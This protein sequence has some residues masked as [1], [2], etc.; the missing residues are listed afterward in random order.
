MKKTLILLVFLLPMT[1]FGGRLSLYL[2]NDLPFD[3]D[4]DYTH[5]TRVE[6][7]TGN[8]W[9]WGLQQ[10]MYTPY[11]IRN[12]EQVPGRHPYAGYL[13]GFG[14]KRSVRQ[15][16]NGLSAY[17]DLELQLGVLGPASLAEQ[18]QKFTHKL[19][20][21]RYPSGWDHQLQNE[22]VVQTISWFGLDWRFAGRRKGWSL[23][24]VPEIGGLLGT[25]Q[26]AP[27]VNSELRAGYNIESGQND[28]EIGIR[29]L[30]S[31]K[32]SFFVLAGV[33]ARYWLRNELLEGN[34][35]YVGN[36]DTLTVDKEDF[37]GCVKF[38]AGFSYG[39]FDF[40]ALVLKCSREYETQESTPN[41]GSMT[42]GWSF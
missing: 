31:S 33:E 10:Q 18:T 15:K 1:V 13:V 17:S 42:V 6:Y 29:S 20:G 16:K 40:R 35:S 9:K 23:H 14:G 22:A 37:T 36:H 19:T 2:E 28:S 30:K 7:N 26:I 3:D 8:G 34:A 25:L 12:S 27:G 41:Y 21:S 5:G 38:G 32:F 11:D 4:S 24:L 39:K